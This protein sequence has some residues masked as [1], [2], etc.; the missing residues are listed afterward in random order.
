MRPIG[1]VSH[2]ELVGIT[3]AAPA[4]FCDGRKGRS[5]RAIGRDGKIFVWAARFVLSF[6]SAK[7]TAMPDF[8]EVN[9]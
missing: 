8:S 7:I 3:L 9:P 4:A 2:G 6:A 1:H 5:V